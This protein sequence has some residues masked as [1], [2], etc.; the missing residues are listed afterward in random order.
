MVDIA[1]GWTECLPL[2]TRDG[3]LIVEAMT[4][5]QCLFPWVIRGADFD[6]DSAFMNDLVVPWSRA[7]KIDRGDAVPRQQEERS[8]FRGAEERRGG[9]AARR[10]RAARWGRDGTRDGARL[11]AAARQYVNFFQ[12][13]FKLKEKRR[14]GATIIRRPHRTNARWLTRNSHGDQARSARGIPHS[15]SRA[16]ACRDPCGAG[17]AW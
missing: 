5:A 13:S 6:D 14:E 3:S 11:Y 9:A 4:R 15:R 8:G 2:V 12:P 1:T 17:R 16:T 7:Q 10:L